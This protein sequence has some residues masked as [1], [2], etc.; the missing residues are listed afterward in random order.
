MGLA[1]EQRAVIE[2]LIPEP[3]RRQKGGVG[4]ESL[5]EKLLLLD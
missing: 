2:P 1:D 3:S 4:H 5:P